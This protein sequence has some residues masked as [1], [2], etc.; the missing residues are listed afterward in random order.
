MIFNK[1]KPFVHVVIGNWN[2]KPYSHL[3]GQLYVC[4]GIDSS[5]DAA[6]VESVEVYD[7]RSN[8]WDLSTPMSSKR[9]R[10]GVA[11]LD[12]HLYAIGGYNGTSYLK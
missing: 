7:L 5:W 4:G 6:A 2:S 9:G 12:Q 11:T 8:S 3:T 1:N 10:V